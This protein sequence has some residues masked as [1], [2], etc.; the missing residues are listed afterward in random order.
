MVNPAASAFSQLLEQISNSALALDPASK[1]K[2]AGMEGCCVQIDAQGSIYSLLIADKRI[3]IYHSDTFRWDVR[4][5]GSIPDLT[6]MLLN[7]RTISNVHIDGD[8][9]LLDELRS[10]FGNLKPDIETPMAR[11]LGEQPAQAINALLQIGLAAGRVL[12]N[13]IQDASVSRMSSHAGENYLQ[14]DEFESYVDAIYKLKLRADR[15]SAQIAHREAEM[16]GID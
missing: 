15:V 8:E 12:A 13:T 11:V 2:L 3:R 6:R 16:G 1:L 9:V 10:I 5:A 7:V 14:R 4:I